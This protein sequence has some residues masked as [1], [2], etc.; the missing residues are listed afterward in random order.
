MIGNDS[1][2]V[3]KSSEK[4]GCKLCDYKTCRKSQYERHLAT[5]KHKNAE[6]DTKMVGND[7]D[8]VPKSSEKLFKCGCGKYYKFDE[9]LGYHKNPLE[10][11]ADN[12]ANELKFKCR[13][14][15]FY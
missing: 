6:N 14:D 4:Y 9:E 7:S 8:L 5:D 10:I 12:L 1:N 15:L 3:P 2:L 11:Q 13:K